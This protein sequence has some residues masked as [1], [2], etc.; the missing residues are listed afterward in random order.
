MIVFVIGCDDEK[1]DGIKKAILDSGN[2]YVQT[3][4]FKKA[5][6]KVGKND[7]V[8]V[9]GETLIRMLHGSHQIESESRISETLS[10]LARCNAAI[11]GVL[12]E[13][14]VG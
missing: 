13:R 10:V 6:E 12:N 11:R 7:I 8:L 2:N 4:D 5:A 9:D 1:T 3:S 14:L